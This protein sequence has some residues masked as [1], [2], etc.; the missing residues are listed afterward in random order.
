MKIE[1]FGKPKHYKLLQ[2]IEFSSERKKM[3]VIV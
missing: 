2:K 3:S 1:V